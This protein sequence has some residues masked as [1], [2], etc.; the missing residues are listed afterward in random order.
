MAFDAFN[1][2]SGGWGGGGNSRY[3]LQFYQALDFRQFCEEAQR[4]KLSIP[5]TADI[6]HFCYLDTDKPFDP[7][8]YEPPVPCDMIGLW[9]YDQPKGFYCYGILL[10]AQE[11]QRRM[12]EIARNYHTLPL[13]LDSDLGYIVQAGET[14]FISLTEDMVAVIDQDEF[15]RKQYV[16]PYRQPQ[17]Q[18]RERFLRY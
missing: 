7:L 16:W 18:R 15:G 14:R 2:E 17:P 4:G 9:D 8:T 13:Q 11:G 3:R 10:S 12:A 1:Y 5:H 6:N